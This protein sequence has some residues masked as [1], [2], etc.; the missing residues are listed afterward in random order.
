MVIYMLDNNDKVVAIYW[1]AKSLNQKIR[2]FGLIRN[3]LQSNSNSN[4]D[5]IIANYQITSE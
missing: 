4:L 5:N 2:K 1:I 3:K